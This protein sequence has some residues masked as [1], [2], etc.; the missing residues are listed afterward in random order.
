MRSALGGV[1]LSC[2]ISADILWFGR[3]SNGINDKARYMRAK[4]RTLS[5]EF[6]EL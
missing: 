6:V 2:N 5:A 1:I 4:V 3:G